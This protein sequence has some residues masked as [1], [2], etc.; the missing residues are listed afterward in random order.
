MVI[1][2]ALIESAL[3]PSASEALGSGTI[4][5]QIVENYF[6]VAL[7]EEGVKLIGLRLGSWKNPAFNYCF[8]GTVYAVAV[9]LGFAALE[10]IGYVSSYGISVALLRAVTSIPG[11]CIFGIYMGYAYGMAKLAEYQGRHARRR[12]CMIRALVVP[13][14]IHGTYDFIASSGSGVLLGLFYLYIIILDWRA[15]ESIKKYS[16]EDMRID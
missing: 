10:N 8:D 1:P 4:A 16:A 12:L 15:I 7:V 13:M 5:Y 9:S 3:I 6:C 2:A 14:L 11:H